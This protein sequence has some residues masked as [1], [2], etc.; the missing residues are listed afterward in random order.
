MCVC[1]PL[2]SRESRQPLRERAI[3]QL[4]AVRHAYR[5]QVFPEGEERD[6]LLFVF[7]M[8]AVIEVPRAFCKIRRQG[9][10]QT[11]PMKQLHLLERQDSLTT[12]GRPDQNKRERR[13]VYVLL[14][15][16]EG[17]YLI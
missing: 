4:F 12:T 8:V 16:V 6:V 15:G 14:L 3:A 11:V 13:I 17:D 2:L 10:I 1:H 7:V 5:L 9:H